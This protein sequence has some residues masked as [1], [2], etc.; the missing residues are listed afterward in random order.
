VLRKRCGHK[1]NYLDPNV[2]NVFYDRL[3]ENAMLL[4]TPLPEDGEEP[5]DENPEIQYD[6]EKGAV[7]I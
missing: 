3:A 4:G 1:L 2:T 5:G 6:V 7:K